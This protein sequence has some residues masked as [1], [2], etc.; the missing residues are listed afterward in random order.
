MR[1]TET[2][3]E[4]RRKHLVR[5][6]DGLLLASGKILELRRDTPRLH[7]ARVLILQHR[8]CCVIRFNQSG[9]GTYLLS[10]PITQ[11]ELKN[12]LSPTT[13]RRVCPLNVLDWAASEHVK[14]VPRL[15]GA[16]SNLMT[17][18]LAQY[19]GIQTVQAAPRS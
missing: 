11:S 18:W 8:V 14:H 10:L 17:W 5:V 9:W 2:D 4:A 1:R 13:W 7:L 19:L 15:F 16:D 3:G 6:T 12:T